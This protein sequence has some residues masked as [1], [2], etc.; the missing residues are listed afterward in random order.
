MDFGGKA[1]VAWQELTRWLGSFVFPDS[2][3][4]C[5]AAAPTSPLCPACLTEASGA[6]APNP[7]TPPGLTRLHC[8]VTL[9][10]PARVLVHGLKYHGQRRNAKALVDLSRPSIQP[11]LFPADTLLVPV[12]LHATRRRE[13]GYNQSHLLARAWSPVLG[14]PVCEA[15]QR[16]RSTGTQTRLSA[17]ARRANLE[18]ALRPSKAF[19]PGRPCLLIDD[20][21]T[22][23]STLSACAAVLLKAGASDVQALS[24][25]WAPGG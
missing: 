23:G 10:E 20:V 3:L 12:P 25:A 14:L 22:T 24:C 7:E 16:T 11:G 5:G 17:D 8:G 19:V 21:A 15:L 4:R 13:R 2:C 18:G 6:I 1:S 9:T